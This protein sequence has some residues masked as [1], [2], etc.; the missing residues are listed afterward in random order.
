MI[1]HNVRAF[2]LLAG[3]GAMLIQT[4]ESG[5][6]TIVSMRQHQDPSDAV[7]DMHQMITWMTVGIVVFLLAA[8]F[9]SV[10][11]PSLIRRLCSGCLWRGFWQSWRSLAASGCSYN[12]IVHTTLSN[13]KRTLDRPPAHD[14][15]CVTLGVFE[16]AQHQFAA[17][18]FL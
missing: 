6:Q 18:R 1:A 9:L 11:S 15:E 7:T 14:R 17:G 5:T 10:T 13:A 4:S 16:R 12:R 2:A 3:H 8:F